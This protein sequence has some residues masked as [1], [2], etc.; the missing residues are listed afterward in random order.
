MPGFS[1]LETTTHLEASGGQRGT[2][3]FSTVTEFMDVCVVCLN[4]NLVEVAADF[5]VGT[6]YTHLHLLC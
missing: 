5:G 1:D 3:Q 2:W 6:W 4:K